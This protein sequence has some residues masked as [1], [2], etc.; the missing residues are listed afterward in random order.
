[1]KKAVVIGAGFSGLSAASYLA[2]EGLDVTVLEKN[3][4]VGGRARKFESDGFLFDMGPSWYWMPE[5]FENYFREFSKEV[6]D[7]YQLLRLDPGYRMIFGKGKQID[8]PAR[9]EDLYGIFEQI[10][11][12]SAGR[13]KSFLERA[14]VKYDIGINKMVHLPGRS[15]F[16]FLRPDLL[17]GMLKLDALTP[18]SRSVR[19]VTGDPRLI[20]LLEFPVLFL[21]A[22]ASETPA[23][24]S[25]MNYA[26]L[27]LGTWYPMGGI[28]RV[29][30]S[31]LALAESLGVKIITS[32]PVTKI[33]LQRS[34]VSEV[35]AGER[36]FPADVVVGSADYHFVEQQLL[37][38]SHRHYSEKYWAGRKM[39]P[40]ALLYYMGLDRKVPNLLHHNLFFD[41]DY[42]AHAADIYDH[43]AWPDKP[44]IYV[45]CTSKTDPATA[46]RGMENITVLIPVAP[47]LQDNEQIR[48][49]YY[50]Y[51]MQKLEK[52]SG[53]KLRDHVIY[54][55]SYAQSDFISDYNAFRGNAYGLANTLRQTAMLKPKMN[56]PRVSNL[57]YAGQLTVP[58]PGV[59]PAL[60]SGKVVAGEILKKLS[61]R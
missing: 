44:A 10:E 1:M 48:E 15:V 11:P 46:P 9:Q 2:R 34:L 12:G 55:R 47:G 7:Y 49:R 52:I 3:A 24:Y 59:P 57:F 32:C 20:Q 61:L 43:P 42:R 14:A 22:T 29:V 60:I 17:M 41:E 30:E 40:S 35:I 38:E 13:L 23:L 21:G 8:V 19:K 54:K 56:S 53:E 58:G 27:V 45:S 16:E 4:T 6:S 33:S 50:D 28:Y 39:A 36:A 25:L 18:L 37:P 26:D 5:I 51:V 31:M